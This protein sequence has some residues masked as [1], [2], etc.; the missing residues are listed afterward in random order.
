MNV[1]R[2]ELLK[3]LKQC[4]PG[5]EN[6]KS[7]LEGADLF[8]FSKGFVYSYNDIISVA[9]PIK[10]DDLLE[11]DIEGAVRAE[12]FY[13]IINKLKGDLI[14]FIVEDD[15]WV[16]K[17][18]KAK[19]Q[20]TLMSGDFTARFEAI[21]P[22]KKKWL[23]ISS[24]FTQG[25]GICRMANNKKSISGIYITQN[26]MTSSDGLQINRFGYKGA[27]FANFWISDASV[28]ELLKVGILTHIQLKGAW[29]HFKT[30]DDTTFSVKT[31]QAE[32]WPYEAINKVL[33]GHERKMSSVSMV[34]P[35]ELFDAIDRASS[36][37]LDISDSKAV[38]LAIAPKRILVS[39]E[40]IAGRYEEKVMWDK[41]CP[42]FDAFDLYVDIE[43]MLFVA[44]RSLSFYIHENEKGSPRMVFT[45]DNSV[46]LMTTLS[47]DD[48]A[49][50]GGK[51]EEN[52][53]AAKKAAKKEDDEE[54]DEEARDA[55]RAGKSGGKGNPKKKAA[56]PPDEEDEE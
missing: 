56:P 1:K 36:F 13:G 4:L 22:D 24:E 20:L 39:A 10:S 14:E 38:R 50:A 9:V 55:I 37:C 17:S 23:E 54:P 45:T 31:L 28:N 5:I 41:E 6:G 29:A 49:N 19:A 30:N 12:E 18:G 53:G 42:Q 47:V 32:D 8:V 48:A 2:S 43:M 34:F 21:A 51:K 15:K 40:R 44:R 16:L 25:L 7:A 35:R 52:K 11:H 3:A 46:H 27:G 33:K 26:D